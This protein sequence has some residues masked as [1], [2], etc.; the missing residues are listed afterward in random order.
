[1]S[2]YDSDEKV[3]QVIKA[4][5]ELHQCD[6]CKAYFTELA[7]VGTWGCKYHPGKYNYEKDEYECCGEK[8]MNISNYD[9]FAAYTTWKHKYTPR[10]FSL[11]CK[12]CDHRSS[13]SKV[14]YA[15][16]KYE[17]IAQLCPYMKPPLDKRNISKSTQSLVRKEYGGCPTHENTLA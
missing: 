10:L 5:T 14:L 2:L 12:R 17:N 9:N 16:V 13:T 15:D 6:H 3:N 1:M 7:N 4:Y 11:G 8:P